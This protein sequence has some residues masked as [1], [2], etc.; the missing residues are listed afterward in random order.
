MKAKPEK[1][2]DLQKSHRNPG[3]GPGSKKW[4]S[5]KHVK[6][7]GATDIIPYENGEV[8]ER[9]VRAFSEDT[10]NMDLLNQDDHRDCPSRQKQDSSKKELIDYVSRNYRNTITYDGRVLSAVVKDGSEMMHLPPDYYSDDPLFILTNQSLARC[11]KEAQV[12]ML[13]EHLL[14]LP[15]DWWHPFYSKSSFYLHRRNAVNEFLSEFLNCHH[16]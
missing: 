10:K 9:L 8:V 12:I 5:K 7:F 6:K 3:S 16:S 2:N 14:P 15:S 13:N 1:R 11:S 4:K